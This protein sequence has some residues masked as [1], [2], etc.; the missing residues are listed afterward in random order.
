[1]HYRYSPH[2]SSD[3]GGFRFDCGAKLLVVSTGGMTLANSC[4]VSSELPTFPG[5]RESVPS[6]GVGKVE[7]LGA[8]GGGGEG[9]GLM[10]A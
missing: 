9:R 7:R 6:F 8:P 2:P 4:A 10:V 3:E 5:F 1:M